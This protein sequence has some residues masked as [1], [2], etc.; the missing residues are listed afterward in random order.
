MSKRQR[1][2]RQFFF[3]VIYSITSS[4]SWGSIEVCTLLWYECRL[5]FIAVTPTLSCHNF[6]L[7]YMLF[8]YFRTAPSSLHFSW[9]EINKNFSKLIYVCLFFSSTTKTNGPHPIRIAWITSLSPHK[10][11]CLLPWPKHACVTVLP[12]HGLTVRPPACLPVNRSSSQWYNF[13]RLIDSIPH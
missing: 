13:C 11:I 7:L 5:L 8:L 6:V 1:I 2:L 12:W 3:S 10:H 9:F 4:F